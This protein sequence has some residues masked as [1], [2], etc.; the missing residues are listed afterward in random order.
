MAVIVDGVKVGIDKYIP[1]NYT[2]HE[3]EV[4]R[5]K[6]IVG[7]FKW[8]V[9]VLVAAGLVFLL[10]LA[11]GSV[12]ATLAWIVGIAVVVSFLVWFSFWFSQQVE[13]VNLGK[14]NG[15]RDD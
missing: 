7:A 4:R 13:L 9:G 8:A 5:A 2:P 1:K 11:S 3:L 6:R 10:S 14:R 15:T 12:L